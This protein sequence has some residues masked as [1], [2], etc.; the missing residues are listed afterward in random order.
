MCN[1]LLRRGSALDQ[2]QNTLRFSISKLNNRGKIISQNEIVLSRGTTAA[3]NF[4]GESFAGILNSD[5]YGAYKWVDLERRQLYWA[6]L[7]R[8]FIKISAPKCSGIYDTSSFCDSSR[9]IYSFFTP[10]NYFF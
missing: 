9:S 4:L 3:Q 8:E 6:H 1:G 10:R 5:R 2:H 7:R